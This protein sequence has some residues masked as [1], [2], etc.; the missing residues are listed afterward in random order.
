MKKLIGTL[1]LGLLCASAAQA[2]NETDALRYSFLNQSGT[3]RANAMGGAFGALGGDMSSMFIN[4]A[5]LGL[6]RKS[7]F[8]VTAGFSTNKAESNYLGQ[9]NSANQANL[10]IG[11]IGM[12]GAFEADNDYGWRNF[13]FG[14][15]YNRLHNFHADYLIQG[16]NTSNSLLNVF[17]EQANGYHP[18]EVTDG[19]PFG[20]GLAYQTYA[21]EPFD[22]AA[23]T[24]YFTRIPTGGSTQVKSINASGRMGETVIAFGGNWDDRLYAGATLGFPSINYRENSYYTETPLDT[25][26]VMER[27]EY[28]ETLNTRGMGFNAKFGLIFA[29]LPFLR[30]GAAVH[31][32]TWYSMTDT[33]NTSMTTYFT[34]AAVADSLVNS[35]SYDSQS[36]DGR[37]D[38]RLSSPAKVIGSAAIIIGKT[39]VISADYEYVDYTTTALRS[40]GGTGNEYNFVNENAQIQQQ[41]VQ[42]SNLKVGTEWRLQPFSIRAGYAL[43]ANPYRDD[44]TAS[45]GLRTTYSFGLGFRDSGYFIDLAYT[46]STWGTDYYLYDPSKV[47]AATIDN[48][49]SQVTFTL[50]FRY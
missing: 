39:G 30:F 18:D 33:W 16:D 23:G 45:D 6:Y 27:F 36:P 22:T 9:S 31:S 4:P 37:F 19:L 14:V 17:A 41:F 15:A 43:H 40:E 35:A 7:E 50:G 5:G 3:A 28:N 24:G 11:N 8:S 47:E 10:N 29:P 26:A 42:A 49:F 48:T 32:P 38:Y 34:P 25:G 21:I 44:A 12:V 13:Q 20:S 46:L 2:Q 1:A